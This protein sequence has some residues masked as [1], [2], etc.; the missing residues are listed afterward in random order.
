MKVRIALLC[1][2]LGLSLQAQE[3]T[4]LFDGK[5]A[6]DAWT[7]FRWKV[8]PE[9]T[10]VVQGG[11]IHAKGE[12]HHFLLHLEFRTPLMPEAQGQARGNSGVYFQSK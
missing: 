1:T 11:D 10:M 12:M 5:P 9:G 4:V 3:W 8:T 7:D 2:L 6:A